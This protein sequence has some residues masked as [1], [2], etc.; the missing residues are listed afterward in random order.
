MFIWGNR[1]E[2]RASNNRHLLLEVIMKKKYFI[3]SYMTFNFLRRSQGHWLK[4]YVK[5][6]K[7]VRPEGAAKNV[8]F[9]SSKRQLFCCTLFFVILFSQVFS[10]IS[11]IIKLNHSYK[12]SFRSRAWAACDQF[13]LKCFVSSCR[14]WSM[15]SVDIIKLIIYLKC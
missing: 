14:C 8:Y 13:T 5:N 4:T 6:K 2:T 1:K 3:A 9:L 10:C 7:D 11:S 12:W 15:L